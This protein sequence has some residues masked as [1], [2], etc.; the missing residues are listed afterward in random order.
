[1]DSPNPTTIVT[2]VVMALSTAALQYFAVVAPKTELSE[3]NRNA[4]WSARD[5]LRECNAERHDL[6]ERLLE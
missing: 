2:A 6:L 3:H 1:M 4:N 5:Q